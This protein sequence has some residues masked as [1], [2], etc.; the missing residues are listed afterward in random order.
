MG[1]G[2]FLIQ[3]SYE[4]SKLENRWGT[5]ERPLSDLGLVSYRSFWTRTVLNLLKDL[6][7]REVSIREIADIT[8][9]R[10]DDIIDVLQYFNLIQY[11]KGQHV[12]CLEPSTVERILEKCGKPGPYIDARKIIWTPFNSEREYAAFKV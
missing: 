7:Y 8:K 5:P 12:L 10:P 9:I 2:K 11:V 4:L 3:F 6:N 1:Y